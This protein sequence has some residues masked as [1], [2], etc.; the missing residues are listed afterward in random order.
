MDG[1]FTII[2]LM[3]AILIVG[4]LAAAGIRSYLRAD[5]YQSEP[6]IIYPESGR[7]LDS[8]NPKGIIGA[9]KLIIYFIRQI[10]QGLQK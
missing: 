3:V 5:Y 8:I 7:D 1:G 6:C 9:E 2:E 4:I 10:L